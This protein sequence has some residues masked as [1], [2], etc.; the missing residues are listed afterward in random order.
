M[1]AGS[2]GFRRPRLPLTGLIGLFILA[3]AAMFQAVGEARGF[4]QVTFRGF[5]LF[6]G[7]LGV[8]YLGLGTLFLLAPARVAWTCAAVIA[9]LVSSP[10]STTGDPGEHC[11]AGHPERCSG[12]RD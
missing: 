11:G 5:Y 1:R 3:L 12:R 2:W 7:V 4:G 8:I 6:G 9:S 10:P